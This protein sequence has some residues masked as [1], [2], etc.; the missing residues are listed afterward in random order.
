MTAA[1][2][3]LESLQSEF[4]ISKVILSTNYYTHYI[5]CFLLIT[6]R[7]VTNSGFEKHATLSHDALELVL[8]YVDN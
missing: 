5:V 3:K 2:L 4:T 8:N 1:I 6:N 7:L